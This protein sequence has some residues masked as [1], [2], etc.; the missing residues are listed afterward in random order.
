[1]KNDAADLRISSLCEPG[2]QSSLQ[3][4]RSM[5]TQCI[6]QFFGNVPGSDLLLIVEMLPAQ[7]IGQQIR[8]ATGNLLEVRAGKRR[9][10]K[11]RFRRLQGLAVLFIVIQRAQPI[12]VWPMDGTEP[13][14]FERP[15]AVSLQTPETIAAEFVRFRRII[16]GFDNSHGSLSTRLAVLFHP[17]IP[18]ASRVTTST[19]LSILHRN[20]VAGL[21]FAQASGARRDL[22]ILPVWGQVC[23]VYFSGDRGVRPQSKKYIFQT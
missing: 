23:N 4:L 21:R 11:D 7:H 16:Q 8:R 22:S 17:V 18:L 3:N 19:P 10:V 13:V 5:P 2:A 12:A 9:R 15:Q 20:G 6:D 1:M 14:P